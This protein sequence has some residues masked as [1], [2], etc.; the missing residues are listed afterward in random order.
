MAEPFPLI[1]S[2]RHW[3]GF[4]AAFAALLFFGIIGCYLLSRQLYQPVVRLLK[5]FEGADTSGK[6]EFA[7]LEDVSSQM[8]EN[9]RALTATL[10]KTRDLVRNEALR[11]LL[12]GTHSAK[13]LMERL[14]FEEFAWLNGPTMVAILRQDNGKESENPSAQFW[15]ILAGKLQHSFS[16]ENPSVC[17]ELLPIKEDLYGMVVGSG[18]PELVKDHLVQA[19]SAIQ[20]EYGQ[21]LRAALGGPAHGADELRKAFSNARAAAEYQGLLGKGR[22]VLSP[23]D[24]FFQ[25][26]NYYYPL[27][28]RSV[29]L[30]RWRSLEFAVKGM[31]A[32]I[33]FCGTERGN[34]I[35][36]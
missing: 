7:F 9:N 5:K 15:D 33:F 3:S 12:Y 13:E 17:F 4:F 6:D 14:P 28:R 32:K 26:E 16:E 27:R 1:L 25:D 22:Y 8:R 31:F 30:R 21:F 29:R 36:W 11:G 35:F 24:L 10:D 2:C 19:L 20:S 34:A 18:N 23:G